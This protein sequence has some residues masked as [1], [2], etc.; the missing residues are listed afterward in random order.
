MKTRQPFL[1]ALALLLTMSSLGH[2]FAA[3]FCP[4]VQGRGCCLAQMVTRTDN[5]SCA[6][7]DQAMDGMPADH[8]TMHGAH[9]M[10]TMDG[11]VMDETAT[12]DM[13]PPPAT[14]NV[15]AGTLDDKLEQPVEPCPHCLSHSGLSN[16]PVSSLNVTDESRKAVVS[17]PLPTFRLLAPPV[18]TLASNRLP[19][20]HAPPGT[21]A[22]LHILNNVFLI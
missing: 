3:A 6:H 20:E 13:S 1:I 15:Y 21:S 8:M 7:E 16:A 2:V 19:G 5:S 10:S 17:V 11:M 9:D 4:R 14:D 22:P 18:I 12:D